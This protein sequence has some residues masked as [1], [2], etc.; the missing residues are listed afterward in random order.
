MQP[1]GMNSIK[2]VTDSLTFGKLAVTTPKLQKSRAFYL[3]LKSI[4]QS[5]FVSR[6]KTKGTQIYHRKRSKRPSIGKHL[7]EF[8]QI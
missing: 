4:S 1:F 3:R 6:K 5:V 7:Q 2:V 8:T